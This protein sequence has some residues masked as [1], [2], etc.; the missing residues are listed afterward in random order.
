MTASAAAPPLELDAAAQQLA[1]TLASFRTRVV[2][3]ESCTAGLV[4]AALGRIPGISEWLCGS[5]VVYQLATKTAWL[6]IPD[7]WFAASGPGVVSAEVATAMATNVL[8]RTPAAEWS[9]GITGHLGPGAPPELDGV[10]YL[11]IARRHSSGI[12]PVE[13]VRVQLPATLPPLSTAN[14]QSLRVQRQ[15]A[16]AATVLQRLSRAIISNQ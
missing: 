16:A 3:A 2:F 5:A 12:R 13:V 11:G 6:G 14:Q 1:D 4:A 9:A 8:E 10:A 7:E 15:E